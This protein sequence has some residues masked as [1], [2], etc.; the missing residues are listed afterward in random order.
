M[1][2]G[3]LYALCNHP[4]AGLFFIIIDHDLKEGKFNLLSLPDLKNDF[5]MEEDLIPLINS[6]SVDLVDNLVKDSQSKEVF[7]VC[8][9]EYYNNTVTYR[10][11]EHCEFI[12]RCE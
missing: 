1:N 11:D 2:I 8:L 9:K 7:D 3:N 6:G 5:V 10:K 4:D 12:S